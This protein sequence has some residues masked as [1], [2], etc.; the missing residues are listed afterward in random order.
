MDINQNFDISH[1]RFIAIDLH[2]TNAVICVRTNAINDCGQV[3]GQT[4]WKGTVSIRN[5]T[6]HFEEVMTKLCQGQ[7][8]IAVVESTYNWYCLADV[9]ERK[10]WTLRIAD[11]ST[12]SQA[13]IKAADDHTDAEYLAER[14]RTGSLKSYAPLK[15]ADRALRD[16]CR[17]RQSLVQDRARYKVIVINFYRNQLSIGISIE[18]IMDRA[19]ENMKDNFWV[20]PDAFT[21]FHDRT[22][23]LRVSTLLD[24]IAMLDRQIE[25]LDDEI[26]SLCKEN[27]LV[28]LCR[29]IPGCGPV[30]ASVLATEIGTMQRFDSAAEFVSYCR[31]CS[32]SKL[33]NGKSKGLGNSKNGN[34]YLSWAMTEIAQHALVYKPVRRV[35]DKLLSRYGGLRVK[36]IRT[37]AAKLARAIFY[38]FKNKE[39]FSM[40]RCFGPQPRQRKKTK[41]AEPSIKIIEPTV[42]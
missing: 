33:S 31:L 19:R 27:D 17:M 32:T 40:E 23:R 21:E 15:Q 37:L 36:A 3:V 39:C 6:D 38:V 42:V 16:L 29:S 22:R 28:K 20:E 18:E 10:G 35:F 9:F 13:N 24:N 11:P 5:G 26:R 4:I 2:S 34:A 12:V 25:Q 14:L 7:N 30:L 1:Y 8:H 41:V